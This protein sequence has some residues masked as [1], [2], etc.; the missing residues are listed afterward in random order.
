MRGLVL[1][2][3]VLVGGFLVWT[4]VGGKE[5]TVPDGPGTPSLPS[6]EQ[7]AEGGKGIMDKIYAAPP[8]VWSCVAVVIVL[9]LLN[10]IRTKMPALFWALVGGGVLVTVVL[11]AINK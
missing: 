3:V 9:V 4:Q 2:L 6:G 5:T 1:L 10:S 11:A 8:W 7:V